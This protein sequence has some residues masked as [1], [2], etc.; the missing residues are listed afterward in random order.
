MDEMRRSGGGQR[1]MLRA[2][3]QTD[4]PSFVRKA[5]ETVSPGDRYVESW[6]IEAICHR[7]FLLLGGVGAG[8]GAGVGRRRL[9]VNLPPRSLKS[10]IVSVA[11]PA[12]VLGH[13]PSA[14]IIVASYSDDLARRLARDFRRV[15]EAA[16][17]RELFPAMRIDARTN[18]EAEVATTAGGSRY[19][20]SVGGTLTGRGGDLVVIDDPIKPM[21]A[22]S[23][24]E[25]RRVN[26]WFDSTVMSRLDDPATAAVVLVMQRVHEDD[27]AGHLLE[28]GG[29]S[30]LR[31]P[32]IAAE[33]EAVALGQGRVHR[34][35]PG[36]LLEPGRLA[37]AELEEARRHLGAQLFE[38]QY[39]QDPIPAGGTLIKAD[40]L[41]TYAGPPPGPGTFA[42]VVQSWD[43]ASKA[44][45]GN[46][47]SVCTSWGLRDGRYWL[48][49]VRRVRVEF[50]DLLRLAAGLADEHAAA[51]VLVE[52]ASSGT[53]LAQALPSQVQAAVVPIRP[54]LDKPARVQRASAVFEAGRVLLPER[55]P[56]A[57]EYRRELLGFP[58]GRHDDQV[59]STTQFLIWAEERPKPR[60]PIR[61]GLVSI[62]NPPGSISLRDDGSHRW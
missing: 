38:A 54:K 8:A 23:D 60:P 12:W 62:P 16:W 20:T 36:E 44:G 51:R 22:A 58:G 17:Y 37:M 18:T 2:I 39:Q 25:R 50:P 42:E 34:R 53:A 11:F 49:D 24:A 27:L 56:W 7:L 13:D 45:G 5:F 3:L 61:I 1:A 41:A 6:H 40:W 15:V 33:A 9:V 52:D 14:R 26:E 43:V 31:L 19:A 28:K 30:L 47:W 48:L 55:A 57:A 32:A 35:A 4:L 46:D 10:T 59:D 29:W 21:D